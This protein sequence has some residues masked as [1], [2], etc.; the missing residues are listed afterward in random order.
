MKKQR[1]VLASVLKPVDDTRMF[2]KIG[3]SLAR[4]PKYEISIY[5]YPSNKPPHILL[6]NLF[7]ILALTGSA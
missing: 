5:G 2:E 3:K 1:I 4:E 6:S 7:L